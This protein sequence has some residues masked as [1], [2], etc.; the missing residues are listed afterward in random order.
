MNKIFFNKKETIVD[1]AING[2]LATNKYNNL[3]KLNLGEN[4]RVIL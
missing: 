3:T 2:L 1:D 4:I